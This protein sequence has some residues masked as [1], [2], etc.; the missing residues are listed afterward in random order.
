MSRT[1]VLHDEPKYDKRDMTVA[2]HFERRSAYL[3]SIVR[4]GV[5]AIIFRAVGALLY[6]SRY[7]RRLFMARLLDSTHQEFFQQCFSAFFLDWYVY[8]DI[9]KYRSL[10]V[11][12]SLAGNQWCDYYRSMVADPPASYQALLERLLAL[13]NKYQLTSI[14]QVGCAGGAELYH[15]SQQLKRPV[16]L[17]G[18]DLNEQAIQQNR[19][20]YGASGIEFYVNDALKPGVIDETHPDLVFTS[21][22]AEYFLESELEAFIDRLQKA[23]VQLVAF[24][25]PITTRRFTYGKSQ[26]STPRGAMAFNHNYGLHVAHFGTVLAEELTQGNRPGISGVWCLGRLT[27]ESSTRPGSL[28]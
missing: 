20:D 27:G 25:E 24:S 5:K 10:I 19:L 11:A 14:L 18:V 9:P 3:L 12:S 1:I 13:T 15:L 28:G 2:L 21:G 4:R 23:G 6:G 26:R 16:R 17:I 22:T 7:R 8:R